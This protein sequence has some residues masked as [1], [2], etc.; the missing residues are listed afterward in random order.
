MNFVKSFV[1]QPGIGT[2][3]EFPCP[4]LKMAYVTI[5]SKNLYF[6]KINDK[7]VLFYLPNTR[8]YVNHF[9]FT[10]GVNNIT[11]HNADTTESTSVS[12]IVEEWGN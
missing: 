4:I 9:T 8:S 5:S 7:S 11:I 2:K 3:I 12:I 10:T 6:E 1:L